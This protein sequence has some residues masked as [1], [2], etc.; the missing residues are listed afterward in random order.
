[1]PRRSKRSKKYKKREDRE[2]GK[3]RKT[4]KDKAIKNNDRDYKT[5]R[6]EGF[7]P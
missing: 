1:M 2:R 4:E 6:K 7:W 5:L 3:A